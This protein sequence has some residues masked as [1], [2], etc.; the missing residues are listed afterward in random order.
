METSLLK[1]IKKYWH[2]GRICPPLYPCDFKGKSTF[3]ISIFENEQC[4][5]TL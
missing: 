4:N 2:L 1:Y 5:Q 3:K